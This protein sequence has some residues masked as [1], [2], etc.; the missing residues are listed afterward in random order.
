MNANINTSLVFASVVMQ[1][2]SPS[3][4]NFG[5]KVVPCSISGVV[6]RGGNGVVLMKAEKEGRG[7][8]RKGRPVGDVFLPW[9]GRLDRLRQF[10][11]VVVGIESGTMP[12]AEIEPQGVVADALPPD[13]G[14]PG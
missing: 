13:D 9:T 11:Q 6:V 7:G 8:W 2:M 10:Q 1:G 14:H 5:W 12:V 4:P 3:G